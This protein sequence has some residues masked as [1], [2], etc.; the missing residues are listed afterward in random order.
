MIEWLRSNDNNHL[1]LYVKEYSDRK[2]RTKQELMDIEE[3]AKKRFA[4]KWGE[5]YSE[6]YWKRVHI[7]CEINIFNIANITRSEKEIVTEMA[8]EQLK[9]KSKKKNGGISAN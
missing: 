4:Q 5:D 3:E 6:D 9:E 7:P 1:F 8:L 2:S